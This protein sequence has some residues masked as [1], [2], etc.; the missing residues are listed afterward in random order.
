MQEERLRYATRSSNRGFTLVEVLIGVAI[1]GALGAIGS[2]VYREQ[3][4]KAYEAVIK[5]HLSAAS[6]ELVATELNDTVIT[7]ATCLDGA[8]LK[9]SS[10][11]TYSCEERDGRTDIFDIKA[12]PMRDIGVGGIL[13]FGVGEDKICWDVC[14]AKGSG[15]TA[16][17]AKS[18]LSL[19]SDCSA[20]TRHERRYSCNC[21]NRNY[22]SCGWRKC[23]C[24]CARGWGC[25]CK[26]CYRC[27]TKTQKIC[28][29]C[30]DIY[31]TT[32]NGVIVD[33]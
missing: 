33:K 6:R 19:S 10:N 11:L 13:S 5:T 32:E 23:N 15:A 3:A 28:K 17:L 24:R 4:K 27:R 12:K 8:G 20:L 16:K 31:Y 1:I 18:H 22:Q 14:N 26:R 29:T 21:S 9:N 2:S 25:R 30:T 7:E